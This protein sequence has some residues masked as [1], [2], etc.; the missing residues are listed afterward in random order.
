MWRRQRGLV[1]WVVAVPAI[2]VPT[3]G[4]ARLEWARRSARLRE[5]MREVLVLPTERIDPSPITH[6]TLQGDG[7]GLAISP[8][9]LTL[10]GPES[11]AVCD[12]SKGACHDMDRTR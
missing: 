5:Q 2:A 10:P 3:T 12:S 1:V 8:A 11:S 4:C 9:P 6:R 7:Y